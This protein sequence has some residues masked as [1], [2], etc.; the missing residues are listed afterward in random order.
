MIIP[1]A[2]IVVYAEIEPNVSG[3]RVLALQTT[4]ILPSC[5]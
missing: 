2:T 1:E 3:V 5:M 4:R